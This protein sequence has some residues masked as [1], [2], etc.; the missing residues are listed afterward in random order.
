M[1]SP[2]GPIDYRVVTQV[3]E[4]K[5]HFQKVWV[6]GFGEGAIFEEKS[7]GWFIWFK[8][9]YEALYLGDKEPPFKSGDTVSIILRKHTLDFQDQPRVEV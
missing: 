6:S 1:E 8:G 2:P 5:E 4:V 9:S 3:V 7:L